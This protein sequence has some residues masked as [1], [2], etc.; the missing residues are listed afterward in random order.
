M[1]VFKAQFSTELER[2][3]IGSSNFEEMSSNPE[4]VKRLKYIHDM[5]RQNIITTDEEPEIPSPQSSSLNSQI[6]L[7]KKP[8]INNQN[9]SH[10][11]NKSNIREVYA[12]VNSLKTIKNEKDKDEW[13]SVTL[14]FQKTITQDPE[15]KVHKIPTSL[16]EKI[17][18]IITPFMNASIT[19]E[20]DEVD[21]KKKMKFT[22]NPALDRFDVVSLRLLSCFI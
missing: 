14:N 7:A 3:L 6:S 15:L 11:S 18:T 12:Q 21:D 10:K 19:I 17:N 4:L 8:P 5:I 22:P 16:S 2:E 20:S 1:S 9:A 13:S